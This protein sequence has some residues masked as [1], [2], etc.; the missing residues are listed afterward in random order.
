MGKSDNKNIVTIGGGTG[1]YALLSGLKKYP[2]NISAIVSMADDGGS[3]GTLRDELGVLPPGDVRQCLVAL[4]DSSEALRKIMNYRFENGGFKGHSFGNIFLSALEKTSGTF[5]EGVEKAAKI[6]NVSGEVIPVSE[7]QMRLYVCLKNGKILAGENCLDHNEEIRLIG[8][9]KIF[10][11]PQVKA[12]KKA[13]ERIKNADF[14]IIGPGDLFGSIM[15]NFLVKGIGEAIKKSRAKII[16]NCNLT[17]KKG[18]T[19][20]FSLEDYVSAVEKCIGKSKIDFVIFNKGKLPE[21]LVAKYEKREGGGSVVQ[22]KNKNFFRKYK[23]VMADVSQRK[24]AQKS[25]DGGNAKIQSFLR[26]DSEKLGKVLML[27]MNLGDYEDIV[28]EII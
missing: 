2:L 22:I 13:V 3:T 8:V 12:S 19:E 10:L 9:K 7:E 24:L 17:N 20:K 21:K 15:P 14:I 16:F 1:S 11:N 25:K 27:V 18:Q 4:S 23:I 28:R 26:H 5:A 6:L